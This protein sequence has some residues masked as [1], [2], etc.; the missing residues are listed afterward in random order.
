MAALKFVYGKPYWE[1][2][3]GSLIPA[4]ITLGAD[5][6]PTSGGGGGGGVTNDRE[7][8][9][10]TY[11]AKEAFAGVDVGDVITCVQVL[12]VS[13]ANPGTVTTIWRN[14]T[15]EADLATAPDLVML[16]LQGG[17]TSVSFQSGAGALVSVDPDHPLPVVAA[18]S[19]PVL[20]ASS[21]VA[22]SITPVCD[23]AAYA[24]GD[25]LFTATEI[26]N[27]LVVGGSVA[28]LAG[29]RVIDKD[30]NAAAGMDLYFFS[31]PAVSMGTL[32]AAATNITDADAD[33]FLGKVSIAAGDWEDVGGAKWANAT[34]TP[35]KQIPVLSEDGVKTTSVW[36]IGVTRGTPT[37]TASG[38]VL[39][40]FI[41]R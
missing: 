14:Q 12:D 38:L 26:P 18:G 22:A 9:V 3:D 33:F 2:D 19:G 1:T 36:V 10:T 23:T 32:N 13:G 7:L 27:A 30:D 6:L 4:A 39:R 34:L 5:L 20:V 15:A 35:G 16:S 29:V 17:Q 24:V 8:V 37:Q 41:V 28:L 31:K 40:P 11:T 21:A 25:V